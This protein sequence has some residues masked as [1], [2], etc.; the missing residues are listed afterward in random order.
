MATQLHTLVGFSNAPHMQ[1]THTSHIHSR[2]GGGEYEAARC[3]TPCLECG[4]YQSPNLT[5]YGPNFECSPRRMTEQVMNYSSTH[6][7]RQLAPR[8]EP[9]KPVTSMFASVAQQQTC[10]AATAPVPFT[11]AGQAE[12][13]NLAHYTTLSM[14]HPKQDFLY[15]H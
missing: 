14:Q 9:H 4:R 7:L 1:I 10:V 13:T 2:L 3:R 11:P 8:A 5:C 6:A 15:A 12:H